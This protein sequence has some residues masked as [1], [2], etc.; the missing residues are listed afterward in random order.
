MFLRNDMDKSKRY[1]N[2]KI[3]KVTRL[4]ENKIVVRCENESMEVEVKKKAGK[5]SVIPGIKAKECL[6]RK[7]L[8]LLNSIHCGWLGLLPYTKA[9][10]SHSKKQLL[11][12]EMLFVGAGLCG[13]KS[14]YQS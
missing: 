1:F 2:G 12:R 3:A 13:A 14:L 8:A 11:M 4:E 5:T 9:R 10:D 6:K 7:C